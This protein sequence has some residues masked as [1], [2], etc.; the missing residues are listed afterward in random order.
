MTDDEIRSLLRE[1]RD[2]PVPAD[3]LTRVRLG[4][5]GRA[6]RRQFPVWRMFAALAAMVVVLL[7][8]VLVAVR[9]RQ[10]VA[11]LPVVHQAP[12]P[13]AVAYRM[14]EV[15]AK[16]VARVRRQ[17]QVTEPG[18]VVR[19]ETEDPDVVILLIGD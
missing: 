8:V 3:S 7:G 5:A 2:E 16:P 18:V 9:S 12:Q 13:P 10:E 4:V 14:T 19:I 17:A 15:V 11:M 1:L 6:G